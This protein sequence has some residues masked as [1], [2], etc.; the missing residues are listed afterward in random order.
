MKDDFKSEP[1]TM[2]LILE[3]VRGDGTKVEGATN[4]IYL[5]MV[6]TEDARVFAIL[7]GI[8][9]LVQPGIQ[10]ALL[11]ALYRKMRVDYADVWEDGE[12]PLQDA[13]AVCFA[14]LKQNWANNPAS[15]IR[16]KRVLS[17]V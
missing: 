5:D 8:A 3:V 10:L 1:A 4:P 16:R 6:E 15:Y 12:E 17:D 13:L 11:H 14:K 7:D 2:R 9:A